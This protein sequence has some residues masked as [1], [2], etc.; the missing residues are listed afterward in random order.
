MPQILKIFEK[1]IKSIISN[2]LNTFNILNYIQYGLRNNFSTSDALSDLLE[3][4]NTFR[5]L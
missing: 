4:V 5:K 1:L 3:S 2:F